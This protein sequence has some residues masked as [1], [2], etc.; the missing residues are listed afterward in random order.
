MHEICIIRFTKNNIESEATVETEMSRNLS[1]EIIS[2]LVRLQE[3]DSLVEETKDQYIS[4][5]RVLTRLIYE[6]VDF[7]E[8]AIEHVDGQPLK[9]TGAAEDVYKVNSNSYIFIVI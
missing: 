7:R 8:Q 5:C 9:H 3:G 2:E 6:A 1:R 4:K